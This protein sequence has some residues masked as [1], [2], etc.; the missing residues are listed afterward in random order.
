MTTFRCDGLDQQRASFETRS[1]SAPQ[2]EG[3]FFMPSKNVLILRC[4]AQQGLEGRTAG[5]Q[6]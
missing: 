1:M 5:L 6:P 4:L 2:D 3:F